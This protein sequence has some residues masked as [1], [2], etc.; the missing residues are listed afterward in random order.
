MHLNEYLWSK[1]LTL[2]RK[3][4]IVDQSK[5]REDNNFNVAQ[6]GHFLF[7]KEE[8]IGKKE[9]MMVTGIISFSTVFS[10]DPS[11]KGSFG[12]RFNSLADS[13]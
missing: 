2:Y 8:S 1:G 6:K 3:D 12:T 13:C 4:K 7:V 5:L 10:E 9:K 11:C